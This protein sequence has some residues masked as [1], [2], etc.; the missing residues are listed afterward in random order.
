MTKQLEQYSDAW[1]QA[2][3]GLVTAS[4]VADVVAKTRSGWGASRGN[5][6]AELIAE[7]LTSQP[8]PS[9]TSAAMQWGVDKEPEARAAYEFFQDTPVAEVGFVRHPKIEESGASPDGFVGKDGLV[10]IKA[11]NTSTHIETLLGA[12]IPG[13]YITQMMWQ[14]SC[15]GRQWC[16]F[17]SYDPRMPADLALFVQR[18]PRDNKRITELEVL[19]MEFLTELAEKEAKLR[20][21]MREPEPEQTILAAG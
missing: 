8:A 17:A 12:E 14:M 19:V 18:V 9:F 1:F 21:L 15:T 2:R 13:K 11:P 16:D 7:R 10:E 6:M 5:Y 3:C 4:R 20:A